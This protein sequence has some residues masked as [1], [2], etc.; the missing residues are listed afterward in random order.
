[1]RA[2]LLVACV[3][4]AGSV[5]A[6]PGPVTRWLM[7]E[8]LTLWDWGMHQAK[9]ESKQAAEYV[10]KDFGEKGFV[11]GGAYYDWDNN[12]ITLWVVDLN[13][14]AETNHEN[15]N[16]VRRAFIAA[17]IARN[18]S[19]KNADA[20]LSA[21]RIKIDRWFSHFG[22]E[23]NERDNKLVEKMSRIIFVETQLSNTDRKITCRERIMEFDAPSKPG[24]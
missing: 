24:P 22:Y 13:Y 6:E 7:D 9:R 21:L 20:A 5:K 1:M 18:Y 2:I 23:N 11:L 4:V 12:E 15:C 14:A 10:W 19:L 16:K 8:P 3:L 17:L